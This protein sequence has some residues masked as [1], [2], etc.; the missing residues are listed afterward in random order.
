MRKLA[1]ILLLAVGLA[2]CATRQPDP[3]GYLA[4]VAQGS[5]GLVASLATN[6][7]EER[8]APL[9][10]RAIVGVNAARRQLRNG[11]MSADAAMTVADAGKEV[12]EA[13][14]AACPNK[15]LD[16]A[17]LARANAAIERM[18]KTLGGQ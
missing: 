11:A 6:A 3:A 13:T 18:S 17:Q 7:C 4:G 8:I 2:A 9:Q 5:A 15:R 1:A 14:R 12:L 10:T 16:Q